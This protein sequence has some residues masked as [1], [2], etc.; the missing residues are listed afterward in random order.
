VKE[1]RRDGG[2]SLVELLVA[3]ALLAFLGG[4]MLSVGLLAARLQERVERHVCALLLAE[5][6]LS[7]RTRGLPRSQVSGLHWVKRNLEWVE[8]NEGIS[9]WILRSREFL[10]SFKVEVRMGAG[11]A[12][13][14]VVWGH[15]KTAGFLV[16]EGRAS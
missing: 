14:R 10:R 7:E 5:D 6:L 13:A 8:E 12:R 1:H 2:H 11:R 4:G 3:L 9:P 15:R 16:R